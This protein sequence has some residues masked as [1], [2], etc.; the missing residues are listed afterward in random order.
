MGIQDGQVGVLNHAQQRL[1]HRQYPLL[2]AERMT[3]PTARPNAQHRRPSIEERLGGNPGDPVA[4]EFFD[5]R[6]TTCRVLDG[7]LTPEVAEQVDMCAEFLPR[8]HRGEHDCLLCR[9]R[10]VGW[11]AMIG[12]LARLVGSE[13]AI[14]GICESCARSPDVE[15]L[16]CE[17]L[18]AVKVTV[19]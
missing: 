2:G 18:G 5:P 19:N 3:S 12:R 6:D 8:V 15:G 16:L 14:F 11:P 9:G 13:R 10:L 1:I 17:R 4:I 7:H